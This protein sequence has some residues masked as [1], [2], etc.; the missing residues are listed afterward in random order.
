MSSSRLHLLETHLV[1]RG[2]GLES[3]SRRH[4]SLR[5]IRMELKR[6]P[7]VCLL[8]LYAFVMKGTCPIKLTFTSSGEIR[9]PSVHQEGTSVI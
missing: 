8:D 4:I 1:G 2:Y 6:K 5:F 3:L 9:L 7:S